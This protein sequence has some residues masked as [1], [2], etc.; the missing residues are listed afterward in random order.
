MKAVKD[1]LIRL[2]IGFNSLGRFFWAY[3]DKTVCPVCSGRD[4][5]Y[6]CSNPRFRIYQCAACG[7]KF[8][9]NLWKNERLFSLY[10]GKGYWD[11]DRHHQGLFDISDDSQWEGFVKARWNALVSNNVLDDSSSPI[12]KKLLEIGCSEGRVLAHLKQK[13]YEVVG[14]EVNSEV[15]RLSRETLGINIINKPVEQCD[16]E[17]ESFDAIFSFHTFEHLAD[18]LSVLKLCSRLLKQ[19]GRIL[20]EVPIGDSELENEDHLHFFSQRSCLLMFE[21]VFGNA[22][23]TDN[24]YVTSWGISTG[25]IYLSAE[26]KSSL[27]VEGE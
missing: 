22:G 20:I 15:S 26:K 12:N 9:G 5:V 10:Q 8:V 21:K 24:S 17:P 7:H 6:C 13:G 19:S 27:R 4:T 16:F 18:P 23:I 25:S 2:I 3:V 1:I 14:C 11:K